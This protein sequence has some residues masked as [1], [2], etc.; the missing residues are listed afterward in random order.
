[1]PNVCPPFDVDK[2]QV[3]YTSFQGLSF[4]NSCTTSK[5]LGV[6]VTMSLRDGELICP[7]PPGF[8]AYTSPQLIS[9]LKHN[10]IKLISTPYKQKR[11]TALINN[12]I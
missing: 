5:E 4:T 8:Q 3:W 6:R 2:A 7:P 10:K 12:K 1:M 9:N 11:L